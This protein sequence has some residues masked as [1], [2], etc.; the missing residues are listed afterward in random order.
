MWLQRKKT[1][2]LIILK[3]RQNFALTG[4][5]FSF[6]K[7]DVSLISLMKMCIIYR[8]Y[9]FVTKCLLLLFLLA[10]DH[11]LWATSTRKNEKWLLFWCFSPKWAKQTR[12]WQR[13]CLTRANLVAGHLDAIDFTFPSGR[14]WVV[15]KEGA[16]YSLYTLPTACWGGRKDANSYK[17][18]KEYNSLYRRSGWINQQKVPAVE[19]VWNKGNS[20][21]NV[22]RMLLTFQF[23]EGINKAIPKPLT[24]CGWHSRKCVCTKPSLSARV[25]LLSGDICS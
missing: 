20:W 7:P 22:Q 3:S 15:L 16:V 1:P 13:A 17:S 5:F 11:N 23:R 9:T 24:R 21:P 25:A 19:T 18:A 14:R 12:I 8:S 4:P 10:R 2:A 6:C